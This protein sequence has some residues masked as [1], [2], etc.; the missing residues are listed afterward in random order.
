M[1]PSPARLS[2]FRITAVA[3]L[4]CA[5]ALA[6]GKLSAAEPATTP[7]DLGF[8]VERLGRLD[9]AINDPIVTARMPGAVVLVRRD[10]RTAVLKAYGMQDIENRK[11]M[12]TDSI[13]RIASMTKAVTTVAVMVLYEEGRFRLNDPVGEYIPAFQNSVVAEP[14]PEGSSE[15]YVTVPARRPITIRDL[16]THTAGLTYG[17]GLARDR[18][19]DAR[20]TG[21][22]FADRDE[23]IGEAM[24]RLARL[25][26][27]GH[28]GER[29]Q[30]GYGTDVLGHFVEVVSGLPL[31]RFMHERI[32]SPLKMVDTHFFLPPEKADRLA[33][34]YGY[35]NGKLILK[36][37]AATSH[38]VNGPRKCFSG[39]AGLLSTASDYGRFL[40]MLL[41]EGELDGVRLL[42]PK[43]VQLM[44][45]NHLGNKFPGNTS[46]YGLGFWVNA[47]P[48]LYG[49]LSSEGAYGWGSAYYP[50]YVVDPQERLV[51][52]FM[53]Q[54][55]PPG[56]F[57]LNERFK[58]LTYQ[59]I[60][61]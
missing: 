14:A 56:D 46:A 54:L 39:G 36:E 32:F 40:Q 48:G 13:F 23:T 24:T 7:E 60:V 55:M 52:L 27:H 57:D 5:C 58:I 26:L 2:C 29:W 30:Y 17:D 41:N 16:L 47:D 59:A 45:A 28:P 38:Y 11:P 9:A 6:V 8:S 61:K 15:P 50:Q 22:Y 20:L 37:T 18:Y 49:E 33:N 42:G 43:T 51:A 35:E 53:T 44:T 19:V 21:W 4:A 12:Q 34:V 10:D 1:I 25:P 3:S 31:D